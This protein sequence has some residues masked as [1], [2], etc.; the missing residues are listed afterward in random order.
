MNGLAYTLLRSI[1]APRLVALL[2]LLFARGVT[3]GA[4]IL[5]LVPMLAI[6]SDNGVSLPEWLQPLTDIVTLPVLLG[7]FVA[8]IAMRS[9]LQ[10]GAA[11]MQG[12]IQLSLLNHW[13]GRLFDALVRTDWRTLS[14]LR[15]SDQTSL[16]V[17]GVDRLGY[18]INNLLTLV[19]SA[20]TLAAIW[21]AALWLSPL[22]ALVAVA[23][24]LLVLAGFVP[25]RRRAHRLGETLGDH[26]RQVQS[27]LDDSLR[28]MRLV[29]SHGRENATSRLMTGSMAQLR[30]AQL[31]FLRASS[32]SKAIL[33]VG[34][35]LLLA[36]I[37][38]IA[39][40]QGVPTAVLLPLIVLFARSVP[41]L[42]S[43]QSAGQQW[44]HSAPALA[45]IQALLALTRTHAEADAGE[46]FP[47]LPERSIALRAAAVRHAGRDRAAAER[48]SLDLPVGTTTALVGPSGAGKST[49]A[50]LFG[51]LL[52]PDEGALFVDERAMTGAALINWR[53]SVAYV[54]QEPV[55]FTA[56]IRENLL[57]A[58]PGASDAD[59]V[60]ALE[61]AAAGFVLALPSGLDTPVGDDG[62]QL[63]GGE[64]QRIAL[65]RALLRDPALL[66]LDEATSAL[67]PQSEAVI[68]GAV[69]RMK[70]Q[71]TIL[72]VSHRGMLTELA[73]RIVRVEAG[74]IVEDLHRERVR[75]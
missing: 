69:S 27:V 5:L 28:A 54:H 45:E 74:R 20:V 15:R 1:P 46:D 58:E 72:V 53:R 49:I 42:D 18:G 48:I 43:L 51:G 13:R 56:T 64:R 67:D 70:G 14:A 55:L 75:A 4:G 3:E 60:R 68:A 9:L 31:G 61:A 47:T 11:V 26:Y 6:L 25:L 44:A 7:A 16:I 71:R 52:A 57:W 12:E 39:V 2:A 23:G 21:A 62:H 32:R 29:K 63:S 34:A 22:L 65:A 50:D 8:L 30:D 35:A 33:H 17:S 38:G 73:D 66:I 10:Y 24:G 41:L 59:I 36:C 19:S 37:V 40:W